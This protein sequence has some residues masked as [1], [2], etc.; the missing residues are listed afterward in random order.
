MNDDDD[1]ITSKM[2]G[3][4]ILRVG[5][6]SAFEHALEL[7]KGHAEEQGEEQGTSRDPLCAI[8]LAVETLLKF[9]VSS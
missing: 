7:G 2:G 4:S 3:V 1:E 6:L 5:D 9:Q 8:G